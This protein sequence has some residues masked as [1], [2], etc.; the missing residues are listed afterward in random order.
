MKEYIF[1][2][3]CGDQISRHSELT[4]MHFRSREG[5]G[6]LGGPYDFSSVLGT[7]P[8]HPWDLE[9]LRPLYTHTSGT[10]AEDI[11]G[12]W[13]SSLDRLE[14]DQLWKSTWTRSDPLTKMTDL[15]SRL[16]FWGGPSRGD[17]CVFS[18]SGSRKFL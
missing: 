17:R 10:H 15:M 2:V 18:V 13:T 6:G 5:K 14:E 11:S 3:H 12:W 7:P 1:Y 16:P 8:R 4:L 9:L